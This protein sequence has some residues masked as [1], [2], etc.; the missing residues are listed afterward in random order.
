MA[1]AQGLAAWPLKNLPSRFCNSF[2]RGLAQADTVAGEQ[3]GV[4][5][6]GKLE[7]GTSVEGRAISGSVEAGGKQAGVIYR[8]GS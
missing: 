1:S 2:I 3:A 7:Q 5:I 6:E 8:P 4:N